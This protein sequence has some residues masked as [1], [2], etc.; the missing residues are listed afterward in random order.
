MGIWSYAMSENVE[1][2]DITGTDVNTDITTGT[3]KVL[4]ARVERNT[5]AF[6]LPEG[7][8]EDIKDVIY[9]ETKV[10][11]DMVFWLPE[12]DASTDKGLR[13][14]TVDVSRQLGG[15]NLIYKVII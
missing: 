10:H 3:V 5:D 4:K 7:R 2:A 9:T 14:S 8:P 6:Q 12:M 1:Y 11:E 15:G 13:P